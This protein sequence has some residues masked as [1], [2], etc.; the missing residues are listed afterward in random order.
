MDKRHH[1]AHP[2]S[3]VRP[4]VAINPKPN[5]AQP[6]RAANVNPSLPGPVGLNARRPTTTSP[7]TRRTGGECDPD[8]IDQEG[9]EDCEDIMDLNITP[10]DRRKS[11]G[12]TSIY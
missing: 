7:T 2:P 11:K 6:E 3:A 8:A 12:T 4:N 1:A 9:P 10:E 5:L